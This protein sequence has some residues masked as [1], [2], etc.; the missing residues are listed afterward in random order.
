MPAELLEP[1]EHGRSIVRGELDPDLRKRLLE[2]RPRRVRS[3]GSTTRRSRPGTASRSPPSPR[4][5]ASSKRQVVTSGSSAGRVPARPA[6]RRRALPKLTATARRRAPAISTTT[7]TSR[8]GSTSCTSPPV[9][10]AGSRSRA[11]W[12]CSPSSSSPTRSAAVSSSRRQTAR[13]SSCAR[14]TSTT[15]R[16]PSGNSMLAYVLLR[17]RGST[18]TTSWNGAPSPS[19]GSSATSCRVRRPPSAG[20]S[21]HSTSTSRRRVRSP[22]S[23]RRTT[24][25]RRQRCRLRPERCRR[26]RPVGRRAAIAGQGPRRRQ[27]GRLCL[28]ALRLPGARH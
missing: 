15:T 18:A 6:L 27:A 8:T 22:S 12:R 11:G 17:S 5:P 9:T 13:R 26:L 24:R 21:A 10:C 19:C 7:R 4:H 3:R 1:F 28:R 14:R 25:S 16:S 23:A 20:R 2:I